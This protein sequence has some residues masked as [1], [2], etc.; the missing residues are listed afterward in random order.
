MRNLQRCLAAAVMILGL[1]W[2]TAAAPAQTYY[3]PYPYG[4]VV[5]GNRFHTF[6]SLGLVS[7]PPLA[8][9]RSSAPQV[10]PVALQYGGSTSGIP[11]G[12]RGSVSGIPGGGGY[13]GSTSGIYNAYPLG[14]SYNYSPYGLYN[15]YWWSLY[16]LSGYGV[17]NY[18]APLGSYAYPYTIPPSDYAPTFPHSGVYR[19]PLIYEP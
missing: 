11:G 18:T 7:V 10:I 2:L 4:N 12:Y 15:P 5:F 19:S 1:L 17:Y 3:T 16:N 9:P 6:Q 14:G 13:S 8:T